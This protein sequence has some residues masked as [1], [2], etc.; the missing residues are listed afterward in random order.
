M[1]AYVDV[2]RLKQVN[3][4]QGHAAGDELLRTVADAIH[5]HLRSYDTLVR[6]GGDEFICALGNCT[7]AIAR[8]RF[9]AITATMRQTLPVASISVG[10]AELRPGETLDELTARGDVAL[11]EAKRSR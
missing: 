3:D 1:L 2:D 8:S 9:Q 7:S 5:K 6:I 10:V 11:Y 4:G